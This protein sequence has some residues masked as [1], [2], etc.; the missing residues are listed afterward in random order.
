MKKILIN[1]HSEK[2]EAFISEIENKFLP[3]LRSVYVK[4][5][6]L[7]VTVP[8][9]EFLFDIINGKFDQLEAEYQLTAKSDLEAF[10]SVGAREQMR[11]TIGKT[12]SDFC[13]EIPG[14]FIATIDNVPIRDKRFQA[15][16]DLDETGNPFITSPAKDKIAESF[17]EY[18]S[19]AKIIRVHEA[20]EKASKSLQ[21]L[22]DALSD[23]KLDLGM[24]SAAGLFLLNLFD[25]KPVL[26][27][28]IPV[29]FKISSR[30]LNYNLNDK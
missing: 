8:D 4:I 6:N 3:A 9:R 20:Q 23:A 26:D 11:V 17:R 2:A 28:E 1:E 22:I 30:K 12:F 7:G 27:E 14:L 24:Y 10:S 29:G 5:N 15:F 13:Q 21:E 16:V 25:I 18:L 19:N